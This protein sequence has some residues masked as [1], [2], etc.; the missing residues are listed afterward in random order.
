MVHDPAVIEAGGEFVLFSTGRGVPMRRSRDLATWEPAGRAFADDV[1]AWAREAYPGAR[2]LWAPDIAFFGGRY[3]LYYSVSTFGSQDSAIGLATSPTLDPGD[4]AYGWTDRGPVVES[5]RGRDAFNAIDPNVVIDAEGRPWLSFGSFFGG[6]RIVPLDPATGKPPAD[7]PKP[8]A[9]AT[10][11]P[12]ENALEAPFI[13]RRG[14]WYYLFA[15]FDHCCRGARSDYN[16]RVGRSRAVTGPYVDAD[17]VPMLEGGG[18]LVLEGAGRYRGP[19]HNAVVS[20]ARGDW[21]VHH[22]YDA[23]QGGRA[24][25]QVRPL[26][27]DGRGFPVAGEPLAAEPPG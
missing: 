5:R 4:P 9:I 24:V 27:W 11:G 25:L 18:T 10:R 15:S 2:G 13:V 14:E 26:T 8:V 21:L 23:E 3:H 17:G 19:G 6:L 7:A 22:T 16:I 12:G 1:P 20:D